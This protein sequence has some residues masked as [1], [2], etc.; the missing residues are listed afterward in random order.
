[1]ASSDQGIGMLRR[2]LSSELQAVAEGREPIG[3]SFDENA[4]PI[5]FEAGQHVVES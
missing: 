1:M 3:V 5:V 4:A 2:M